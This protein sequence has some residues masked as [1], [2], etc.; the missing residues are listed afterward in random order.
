M[1]NK[2]ISLYNLEKYEE[3]IKCY[4][5]AIKLNPKNE[6]SWYN[7]GVSFNQLGK[8]EEAIKCYDELIKLNPKNENAWYNKGISLYNLENMKKQ[9]NVMMKQLN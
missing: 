1:N 2:G 7:K 3:S 5:E 4:D 8:Y 6:N 9:L